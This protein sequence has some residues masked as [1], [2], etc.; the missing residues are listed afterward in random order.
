MDTQDVRSDELKAGAVPRRAQP[1][2]HL[3][4]GAAGAEEESNLHDLAFG[5]SLQV[6]PQTKGQ[7]SNCI[8]CQSLQNTNGLLEELADQSLTAFRKGA[9]KEREF[10]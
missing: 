3:T 5:H 4:E 10:C 9:F 7:R 1:S 8:S 6:L 2:L